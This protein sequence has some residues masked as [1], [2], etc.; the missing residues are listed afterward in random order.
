MFVVTFSAIALVSFL[1]PLNN[2]SADVLNSDACSGLN[3]LQ[4][5]DSSSCS[6]SGGST[7]SNIIKLVINVL[8]LVVGFAAVLMIMIGGFK[9]ITSG[10]ESSNVA[11]GR[12]TILYSL[13]GLII[14][15]LAQIIVHFTLHN[16]IIA[17]ECPTNHAIAA[18]DPNCVSK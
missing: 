3:E 5:S 15:A 9:F 16:T 11:S 4:G 13:I 2:A 7:I 12:N 14:V 6:S 1:V 17:N 8:S 10:G 18:S